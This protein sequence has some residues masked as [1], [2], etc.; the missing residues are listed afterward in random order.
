VTFVKNGCKE[1]AKMPSSKTLNCTAT[2]SCWSR[3]CMRHE[4]VDVFF[5]LM[6][7]ITCSALSS[8]ACCATFRRIVE[9]LDF[10]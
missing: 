9:L 3:T 10:K 2:E 1:L 4:A 7:F 5:T 6:Q 8:V